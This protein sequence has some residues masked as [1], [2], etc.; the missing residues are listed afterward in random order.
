MI[1]ANTEHERY[2]PWFAKAGAACSIVEFGLE[3]RFL[4]VHIQVLF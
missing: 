3:K 1:R 2:T 4:R